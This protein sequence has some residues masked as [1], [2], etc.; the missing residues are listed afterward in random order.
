MF[1]CVICFSECRVFRSAR[2]VFDWFRV[3][4]CIRLVGCV[5][6]RWISVISRKMSV[7]VI[8]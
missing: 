7:S 6:F 2:K 1:R 3:F 5:L 4:R 8:V